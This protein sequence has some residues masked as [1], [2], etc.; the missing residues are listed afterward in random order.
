MTACARPVSDSASAIATA[1]RATLTL[2]IAAGP[3]I[4]PIARN[5]I[6]TSPRTANCCSRTH[7]AALA[8]KLPATENAGSLIA[9]KLFLR[10]IGA[11]LNR[12]RRAISSI[13][14]RT[15]PAHNLL[16]CT[17]KLAR[18]FHRTPCTTIPRENRLQPPSARPVRPKPTPPSTLN[19][20]AGQI[21][22]YTDSGG[23][24][25]AQLAPS[26]NGR[27]GTFFRNANGYRSDGTRLR[28]DCGTESHR[29]PLA[30]CRVD[31]AGL[32]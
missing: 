25:V 13:A 8:P 32:R 14:L 5:L 11:P 22:G 27:T 3:S 17:S 29:S 15:P 12:P 9:R 19:H 21:S 18:F 1:S 10:R 4:R 23:A 30:I 2:P 28:P 31:H 26:G 20:K 16:G 7:V 6:A 24:N